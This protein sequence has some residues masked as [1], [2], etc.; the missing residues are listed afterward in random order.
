MS[1]NVRYLPEAEKDLMSLDGSQRIL[2]RKAIQKVSQNSLPASEGGYGKPPGNHS[3]A[4]LSGFLKIKLRDAGIRIVYQV[5]R[6]ETEMLVI[7]IGARADDE[8]YGRAQDR[9]MKMRA[10]QRDMNAL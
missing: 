3:R 8:V 5:V 4:S 9:A 7:V 1:W 2:V 6:T 10:A